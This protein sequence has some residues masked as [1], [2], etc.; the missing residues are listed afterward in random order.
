MFKKM[1]RRQKR[2]ILWSYFFLTPQLVLYLTLTILP[3]FIALPMIFSDRLTFTDRDWE[4]VGTDNIYEI[5]NDDTLRQTYTSALGRTLRFT[6]MNYIMVYLF[7]L[8]LALLMYEIG[9]RGSAFTVIYLPYMLS[10][11]ALGFMAIMLFSESS[12]TINLVLLKLGW[13]EEPINI[14]EESG[15]TVILPIIV[16]WRWAGFYLAI[17]L[18][19]LLSIPIETIEA[20]IVDG[21]SYIQR[22]FRVYFPQ[23]MPSFI[24]ATIFALLNS[25]NVFDELVALGGLYQNKAAEFISIVVFNF[26]FGSNRLALGMTMAV[27]TFIPLVLVAYGLQQLQRRLQYD[28]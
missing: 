15:T 21:A 28:V 26:G 12:G 19:G 5:F 4:Y 8:S 6:G 10:G 23:M 2:K 27:I 14:K 22:L 20:A 24:I 11:L 16:G 9:F 13:L 3:L 7:G 1:P 17:F 25:F 18:A